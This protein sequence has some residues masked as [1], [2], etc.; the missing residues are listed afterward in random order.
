MKDEFHANIEQN[1][2]EELND[3]FDGKAYQELLLKHGNHN[4]ITLTCNTDGARVFKS[5]KEPSLWPLQFFVNE[6]SPQ[7]RF[8]REN[9]LIA[10]LAFGRTP[11]MSTLLRPFI[12][13]TIKINAKGGIPII[14]NGETVRFLVIPHIWT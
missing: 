12:E 14:I 1:S 10:A 6:I 5:A 11:D 13:E 9:L 7:K 3:I 2:N 8:K 4:F